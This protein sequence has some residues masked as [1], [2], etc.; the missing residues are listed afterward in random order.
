MK[1]DNNLCSKTGT[2]YQ[3]FL[4]SPNW[5]ESLF[6]TKHLESVPI[7]MTIVFEIGQLLTTQNL[8]IS[9]D[10]WKLESIHPDYKLGQKPV[11]NLRSVFQP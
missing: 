7:T 6:E 4:I 1:N 2:K 9:F 10:F 3:T 11:Q 5:M 8:H